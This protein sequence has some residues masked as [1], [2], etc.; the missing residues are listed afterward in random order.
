VAGSGPEGPHF[1]E[2]GTCERNEDG[3]CQVGRESSLMAALRSTG[4]RRGAPTGSTA[5]TCNRIRGC[6][7]FMQIDNQ[8]QPPMQSKARRRSSS[9]GPTSTDVADS[10]A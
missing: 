2:L 1:F 8:Q 7:R 5:R 6:P 3:V 10:G 9:F 4:L